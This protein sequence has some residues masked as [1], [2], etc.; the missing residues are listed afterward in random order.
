MTVLFSDQK[1]SGELE[2]LIQEQARDMKTGHRVW[3][4]SLDAFPSGPDVLVP[5]RKLAHDYGHG[6]KLH[7][8]T[9]Y[10]CRCEKCK[11]LGRQQKRAWRAKRKKHG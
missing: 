10:G 3:S 5:K 8:Y 9:C 6:V 11:A 4:A 2:H 7:Y 1:I